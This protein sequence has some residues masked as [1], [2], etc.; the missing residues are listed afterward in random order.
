MVWQAQ[1]KDEI[2]DYLDSLMSQEGAIGYVL[3]NYDGKFYWRIPINFAFLGIPVKMFPEPDE[4][5]NGLP[6]V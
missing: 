1:N 5:G 2:K 4:D 6:A 3:I